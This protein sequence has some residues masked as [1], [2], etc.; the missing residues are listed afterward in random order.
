MVAE[1]DTSVSSRVAPGAITALLREAFRSSQDRAAE[2][3]G[4]RCG[5]VVGRFELVRK[6]GRGGFGVVF[7]A[8]DR[9]LGRAVAFKAVRMVGDV[10]LREEMLFREAEAA[11]QLSH[12]NIVT[13]H[14][15]GQCEDGPYLVMEL[16]RGRTL[17]ERLAE[18]PLETGEAIRVAAEVVK[19]VAHAHARGVIHRDLKPGNV[20]L[21]ED[22]HVKVLD[23]GMARAFGRAKL[24]GGTVGYMAPEQRQ[25]ASED[26]RT[27]V[28]ALGVMLYEML[29]GTRPFQDAAALASDDEAPPLELP[30]GAAL[31]AVVAR[32][33]AKAP[34][35]RPRDGREALAA[36]NAAAIELG[37]LSAADGAARR[38]RRRSRL[39]LVA[40]S[41]ILVAAALLLAIILGR[42]A[43][44]PFAPD[45]PV[46][47]SV[48]PE[49]PQ[50]APAPGKGDVQPAPPA[51]QP[52]RRAEAARPR[53]SVRYCRGSLD[54]VAT[55]PAVS[56]DGVITVVADPFGTVFVN[57]VAYGDT[58]G[59][60]R[61]AAGTYRIR[62]VHPEHGSREARVRV[63]PGQRARWAADFVGEP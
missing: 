29:A 28:F 15:V 45:P 3:S 35:D 21:C 17:G 22:G 26:E 16:L 14:D 61:V 6:L 39:R 30:G 24:D 38:S 57:G 25:G 40:A 47:Q 7:E 60:C 34:R 58:P 13:L 59:E 19:G 41:T 55:P 1:Q 50:P 9:T 23:F 11:A 12:P 52:P 48:D 27:D 4:F 44:I 49:P 46:A 56:G 54:S 37:T 51:A 2:P 36:L 43:K 10:D 53:G 33:L 31:S 5:Q 18:G 62:V 63:S 8:F 20:F 42:G 32:M